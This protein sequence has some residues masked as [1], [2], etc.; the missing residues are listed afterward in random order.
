MSG[1]HTPPTDRS[2]TL[3]ILNLRGVPLTSSAYDRVRQLLTDGETVILDGAMGTEIQARGSNLIQVGWGGP[4]SFEEPDL[5]R[6]IHADYMTA[7]ADV[8]TTNT[9]R[10]SRLRLRS[11]GLESK[12]E[13]MNVQAMA[14]A[15]EARAQAGATDRVAIAGAVS[16]ASVREVSNEE[17]GYEAYLEQ[18]RILATAGADLILLEMLKD[19]HQTRAALTAAAEV[20]LPVWAGFS[21]RTDDQGVVRALEGEPAPT[22]DDVLAAVGPL[23]V[24]AAL[25][26]HT[27]IEDV[28]PALAVLAAHRNGPMGAYPHVGRWVKPGWEFSDAMRPDLMSAEASGWRAKGA[29]IFGTCC[30]LGPDYTADLHAKLR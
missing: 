24:D 12:V 2:A 1:Q 25:I 13:A 26:M 8:I 20:G 6:G 7:G 29:Q 21:C 17:E 9:F 5:V 19:V 28:A 3:A 10:A 22:F 14:L 16:T 15:V 11:D 4:A 27:A 18:A 23:R 30:G